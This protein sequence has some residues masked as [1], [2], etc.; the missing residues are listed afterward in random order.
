MMP[1]CNLSLG[2]ITH[3]AAHTFSSLD[4]AD[5]DIEE[6]SRVKFG[7]GRAAKSLGVE[8]ADSFFRLRRNLLASR[9][10]VIPAP[11]T[12]VPV[13]ATLLSRHFM[14]RL[15]SLLVAE[16]A[17]PVEWTLA[18]RNVTYNVNYA[19][20]PKADRQ[21]LLAE[22]SI[23]LNK[24]FVSGKFLIFFD[25]CRITGTHEDKIGAFLRHEGMANDC[26]FV[27]FAEYIGDDPS[28]EG[29][30]NH[31][32]IKSVD[33]LIALASEAGHQVTTR[34]IRLLLEAPAQRIAALLAAAPP[35]FVEDAFHAAMTKGYHLHYPDTFAHLAR[36][37]EGSRSAPAGQTLDHGRPVRYP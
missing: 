21:Q 28:I 32:A 24:D 14:N 7:S 34:A 12:T 3:F 29:R 2:S 23:Y 33:D 10:V 35:T 9:C 18:H 5:F 6:Y 25:D 20:L 11:S 4:D 30:L 8:T 26:A 17:T 13:A 19:D 22:D 15:N 1:N 36:A 27:C 37:A 16:G 31:A